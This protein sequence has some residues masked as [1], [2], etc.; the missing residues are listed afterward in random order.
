MIKGDTCLLINNKN[1]KEFLYE[2]NEKER[3]SSFNGSDAGSMRMYAIS[4]TCQNTVFVKVNET[5]AEVSASFDIAYTGDVIVALYNADNM[6]VGIKTE[7]LENVDSYAATVAYTEVPTSAKVMVW[8]D[9]TAT[10]APLRN[11]IVF[12]AAGAN[13]M[14][15]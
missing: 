10:C 12:E 15:E 8:N 2:N 4:A 3:F 7:K 14:A 11:A 1:R 5:D 6:L 13:W 9:L